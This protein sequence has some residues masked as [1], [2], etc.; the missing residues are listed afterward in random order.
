MDM[1]IK[2]DMPEL[3]KLQQ[4]LDA[5]EKKE[6]KNIIRKGVVFGSARIVTAIRNKIPGNYAELRQS[7]GRKNLRQKYENTFTAIIGHRTGGKHAGWY[8]HILEYGTLGSRSEALANTTRRKKTWKRVSK[9]GGVHQVQ[10][11]GMP[12][13]LAAKPH[14]RPAYDEQKHHAVKDAVNK[15]WELV[16]RAVK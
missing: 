3:R 7:I 16:Q 1:N 5:L 6:A 15:M 14:M 10:R 13:G 2:L 9:S 12:Q 8:G 11:R 4:K